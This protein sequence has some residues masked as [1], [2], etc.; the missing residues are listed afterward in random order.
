M[1]VPRSNPAVFR[2]F[3]RSPAQVLRDWREPPRNLCALAG[4]G[5]SPPQTLAANRSLAL[6]VTGK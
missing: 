6:A 1:I 5:K 2:E 4:A 3:S